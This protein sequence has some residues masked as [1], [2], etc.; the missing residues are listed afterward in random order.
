MDFIRECPV[1]N[2]LFWAG[3]VDKVACNKHS[4]QWRKSKQRVKQKQNQ[5][6]AEKE[7]SERKIKKE[8]AGMSRT[9]VAILNAIV[10]NNQYVF[11]AIDN[12]AYIYLKQSPLVRRVPNERI[13]RQTLKMLVQR[14]YLEHEERGNPKKDRYFALK[15]L[16]DHR[17]YIPS[18]DTPKHLRQK[19]PIAE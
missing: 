17:A 13:V 4:E 8:L 12:E 2:N 6:Q 7:A 3:R 5:E 16:L 1:C 18:A 15:K 9:A 11:H 10:V 19:V 14:G